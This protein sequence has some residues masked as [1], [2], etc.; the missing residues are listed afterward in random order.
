MKRRSLFARL[1][2]LPAVAAIAPR[3]NL[4]EI[5]SKPST[6]ITI[7][8]SAMRIGETVTITKV[9]DDNWIILDPYRKERGDIV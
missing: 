4:V 1:L 6:T 7:N 8:A 5:P 2:A 9:D 3:L